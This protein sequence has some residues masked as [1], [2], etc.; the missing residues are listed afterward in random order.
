MKGSFHNTEGYSLVKLPESTG[1]NIALYEFTL[2]ESYPLFFLCDNGIYM[3]P[4]RH[5]ITDMGSIPLFAQ[6]LIPKDRCLL[7]WIF[8]D[9]GYAK[10]GLYISKTGDNFIFHPMTRGELDDFMLAGMRAEKL[11]WWKRK[12]VYKVV[13][14]FGWVRWNQARAAESR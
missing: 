10:G 1:K 2:A 3:Q 6:A 4:D 13:R 14:W 11:C 8:H 12:A 7:T 5:E 9:S